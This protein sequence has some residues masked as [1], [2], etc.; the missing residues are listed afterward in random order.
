MLSF[1]ATA[2]ADPLWHSRRIVNRAVAEVL[3]ELG[4]ITYDH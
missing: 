2:V 4:F 1:E 3:I